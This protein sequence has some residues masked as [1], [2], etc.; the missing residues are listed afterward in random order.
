LDFTDVNNRYTIT[1]N[2]RTEKNREAEKYHVKLSQMLKVDFVAKVE[3]SVLQAKKEGIR[4]KL[5]AL[6]LENK[7]TNDKARKAWEDEKAKILKEVTDHNNTHAQLRVIYNA[8][9]DAADVLIKYG[10]QGQLN[11]WLTQQASEI[12]PQKTADN[13]YPK[14]PAYIAEMP[15][16]K[17]LQEVDAE[18]LAASETN[19]KA[20]EYED[21]ISYKLQTEQAKEKADACDELVKKIEAE[22]QAMIESAKFPEGISIT[23]DGITIDGFALDRN[24]I[25]TSKL[26]TTALRIAAMNMGEVRTLYFDA[27]FLD[28]KTLAGIEKWAQE[29]DL[30]LLIEMPDREGGEISYELVENVK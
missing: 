13:L 11:E 29:N 8:C 15:D 28:N 21:Y 3:L 22:R 26:Y 30:Q 24:Q 18:I 7:A 12:L 19:S 14:E 16:D 25:S 10:C 2:D 4:T 20:K 27:S 23:A 5:N 6:Y 1:Y 9:C 17:E